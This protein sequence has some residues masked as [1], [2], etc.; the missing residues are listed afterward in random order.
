MECSRC[1]MVRFNCNNIVKVKLTKVG[2][3]IYYHRNDD[4]N[5]QYQKELIKPNMPVIDNE[6]YSE[7]QLW[8]LM[9]IFGKH[10]YNGCNP[11]FETEIL[12]SEST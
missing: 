12:F 10:M 8:E 2:I 9:K 1:K 6:G 3:D 5:E 4:I 7:F 11:P